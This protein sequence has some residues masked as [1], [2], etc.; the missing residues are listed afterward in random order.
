LREQSK[1]PLP[2]TTNMHPSLSLVSHSLYH[3]CDLL[4]K[5][6]FS[7]FWPLYSISTLSSLRSV[8]S[9]CSADAVWCL[10]LR[11]L[12]FA[13]SCFLFTMCSLLAL[14]S[15]SPF[16]FRSHS[17][18]RFYFVPFPLGFCWWCWVLFACLFVPLLP[19]QNLFSS[20]FS[21]CLSLSLFSPVLYSSLPFSS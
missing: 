11:F 12:S 16:I 18:S 3:S 1:G 7:V 9:P 5:H 6:F 14:I 2:T 17:S 8:C 10:L 4:K 15:P 13:V 19:S 21:L 20:I